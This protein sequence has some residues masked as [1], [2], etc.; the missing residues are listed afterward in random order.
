MGSFREHNRA[1]TNLKPNLR[2]NSQNP[3]ETVM[4]NRRGDRRADQS[5]ESASAMNNRKLRDSS[6]HMRGSAKNL[7]ELGSL[8]DSGS[9]EAAMN[10]FN[11]KKTNKQRIHGVQLAPLNHPNALKSGVNILSQNRASIPLSTRGN[12]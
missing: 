1:L 9:L 2:F 4:L 12:G 3:A 8:R 7:Q 11:L 10:D 5:L 6:S